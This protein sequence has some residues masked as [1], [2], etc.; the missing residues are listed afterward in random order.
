MQTKGQQ[1]K[2]FE[3][4]RT[5][6]SNVGFDLSTDKKLCESLATPFQ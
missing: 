3:L 2:K 1:D 4:N 5:V 6:I